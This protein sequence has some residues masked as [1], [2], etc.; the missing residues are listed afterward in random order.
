MSAG[1]PNLA[2]QRFFIVG[3]ALTLELD[4]ETMVLES[5]DT[6]HFPSTRVHTTWNHTS[7]VTTILHTCTMDVF[8]D[9]IPSGDPKTSLAVT[10]AVNRRSA[11]KELKISKGKSK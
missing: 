8:G 3:G 5:G 2:G 9:G 7:G 6:A 4:G 1:T 11:P 10:R